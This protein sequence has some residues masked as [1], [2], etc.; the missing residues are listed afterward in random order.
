MDDLISRQVAIDTLAMA[1]ARKGWK[2][3]KFIEEG[4]TYDNE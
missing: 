3:L 4:G 1:D 2:S